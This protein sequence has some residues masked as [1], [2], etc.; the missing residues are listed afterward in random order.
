MSED[1]H[2]QTVQAMIGERRPDL[3]GARAPSPDAIL[4][5]IGLD[6][7]TVVEILIAL[8]TELQIDLETAFEGLE[9]PRTVGDLASIFHS[10]TNGA[11]A[12]SA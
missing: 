4:S 1:G 10:L 2:L 11:Q 7:L 12:C 6:S 5:E 3:A 8:S 9:P